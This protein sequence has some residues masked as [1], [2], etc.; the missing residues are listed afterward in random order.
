MTGGLM[1]LVGK[2]AQDQ[3]VTG[4]PSFTHFRSVYKR[5]TEFAME[6]F[7]LYFKT[8][9]LNLPQSG[10]LT[11]RA[12]VERY[13]QLIHDCY[14]TLNL[15]D[16]YSSI[17]PVTQPV[18][19]INSAAN[20]IGYEFQW[21][22][23]IGYNM[24]NYVS[25]LINGQEIVRHT[26][27]WLKLYAALS[28][29]G[30]KKKIVDTM[31]GN[32]AEMYDPANAFDRVNQYP[33]AISKSDSQPSAPSIRGRT[34]TIPLH[35]WF[36]ESVKSALPL[37]ALQHSEVE[38]V[39]ELKNIYQL[40]TVLDTN[41]NS[42]TFGTRIAPDSSNMLF[43][44][45]RF[46]SPPLQT[47]PNTPINP[48]LTTWKLNPFIEAN[49]IF[50]SDPELIHIAKTDQSFKITQIDF[51]ETQGQYGPSND[52]ELTMRNLCT[53]VVWVCQRLDRLQVNDYD[54]YTNWTSPTKPPIDSSS[55]LYMTPWYSSGN[56][57]GTNITQRDILIES[58]IILDGKERFSTKP[59]DFFSN[60][61]NYRHHA[62]TSI[63]DLPGVYS[64]SFALEHN[65]DQPSGHINGSMFN[66]TILRNTYIQPPLSS[67]PASSGNVVC[68]LKS[69]ASNPNPTAVNP[70]AIGTNGKLLY[71][72]DELV[73]IIRK[74]DSQT[75]QYT[76]NVRAYVESYNF[77]RVL[78]GIANVVFSS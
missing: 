67:S 53:R 23:N 61:Q 31:T 16:I 62:G 3:L 20:A 29:D 13:A 32:I 2:G 4:N 40:F 12:K 74:T 17:V 49:Y 77:L 34:L 8:T 52:L 37:I 59:S 66:K 30:N 45:S 78:G 54:N 39:V 65:S 72:P 33:H 26:G 43:S 60:L 71:S 55:L 70:N 19:R 24:I 15:P 25:I 69:T 51:K 63:V 10:N 48:N 75:L 35:F 9:N 58:A 1:Q 5:H 46:L 6:H 21:V 11:L 73:T 27:E 64:Y 50:L 47:L 68:V 42:S 41:V 38:I 36:C 22:K 28:F 56:A 44:I 14:L 76:Y 7:E 18:P 57:Q